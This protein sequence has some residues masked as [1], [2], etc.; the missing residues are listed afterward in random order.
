MTEEWSQEES[1]AKK[2]EGMVM[3]SSLEED[4]KFSKFKRALFKIVHIHI[5]NDYYMC[6]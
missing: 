5:L 2:V 4:I 1:L 6:K 3:G